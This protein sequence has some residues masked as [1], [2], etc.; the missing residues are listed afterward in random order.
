MDETMLD[1]SDSV[2]H[3]L[4]RDEWS[5]CKCSYCGLVFLS[6]P[7]RMNCGRR[8]CH[9]ENAEPI[10]AVKSLQ[11]PEQLW[12]LIHAHF[13]DVGFSTLNR[14]D[15]SNPSNRE[16]K[17]VGAGLQ[18]FEDAIENDTPPPFGPLFVPQPAIRLNYWASVGKV[19]GTSTSF[20]NLCTEHAKSS[21][22]DFL[23]H[24]DIWLG[25]LR[26]IKIRKNE[27]TIILS[28]DRWRGGPFAGHCIIFEVRGI[29]I[30]DAILIDE[31]AGSAR[32][33]LPIVDFSFGLE[34]IVWVVNSGLPYHAF[35]GPLPETALPS[36][37]RAIDRIRTATLMCSAGITPSSRGHGRFLRRAVSDSIMEPP[38]DFAAALSHAHR[39]WSNFII[40]QRQLSECRC[41]LESELARSKTIQIARNLKLES[42]IA[43]IGSMKSTDDACRHLLSSGV[44]L[45]ELT[46]CVNVSSK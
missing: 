30:G 2:A 43:Y 24:I 28:S 5:L 36:N 29:E 34:R 3:H 15:I 27:I 12:H 11:F 1:F 10:D 41:I 44:S 7:A 14:C 45:Q 22:P 35:I 17:F 42:R 25:L 40:P 8:R 18:I 46:E 37:E 39:Y 20:L 21:L 33:F 32:N 9:N 26:K 16:T 23:H 31:S 6:S 4:K 13:I 38:I 19:A